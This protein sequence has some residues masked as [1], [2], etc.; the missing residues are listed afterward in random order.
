MLATVDTTKIK[1]RFIFGK[2]IVKQGKNF[3]YIEIEPINGEV[4]NEIEF[5]FDRYHT[6]LSSTGIPDVIPMLQSFPMV[7]PLTEQYVNIVR[8]AYDHIS[9][10]YNVKEQY[11]FDLAYFYILVSWA[12]QIGCTAI[13]ITFEG[14][15]DDTTGTT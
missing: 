13:K 4:H 3:Y 2:P 10:N 1:Y 9:E 11:H 14:G 5:T 8:E 12:Y 15:Y 7:V 6:M